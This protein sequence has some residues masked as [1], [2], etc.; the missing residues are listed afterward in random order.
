MGIAGKDVLVTGAGGSIGSELCRQ[1]LRQQPN[2]LVLF[3]NSEL[4]LYNIERELK[5]RRVRAV[6]MDVSNEEDVR[7]SFMRIPHIDVIFH[8]AAYKHVTICE[9]NA[10]V[11]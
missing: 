9:R 6:L 2:N 10:A 5:D 3:E 1:I 7:R 8:A 4:A 11:R